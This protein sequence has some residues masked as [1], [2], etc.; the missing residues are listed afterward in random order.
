MHVI[1]PICDATAYTPQYLGTVS[2]LILFA[3][4][5]RCA[6][7]A[8]GFLL[9]VRSIAFIRVAVGSII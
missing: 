1:L 5:F 7:V 8:F 9:V 6:I 3:F 2:L 4:A